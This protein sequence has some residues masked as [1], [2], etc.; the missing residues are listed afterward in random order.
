M[1][2]KFHLPWLCK[3]YISTIIV[4]YAWFQY[5]QF[6]FKNNFENY[7]FM[8]IHIS[9]CLC[10]LFFNFSY[11]NQFNLDIYMCNSIHWALLKL[12]IWTFLHYS[13]K[14]NICLTC[15][16]L[17]LD[18]CLNYKFIPLGFWVFFFL[19]IILECMPLPDPAWSAHNQPEFN[20]SLI[21]WVCVK[22]ALG[23]WGWKSGWVMLP[24]DAFQVRVGL[25][26]AFNPFQPTELQP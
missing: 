19:W 16:S 26:L 25:G 12:N 9:V 21:I 4:L 10:K 14:Y 5:E 18:I 24:A 2:Q 23:A 17:F 7:I 13:Y 8:F 3:L 1:V 11:L 22:L 6:L 15:A 20:L